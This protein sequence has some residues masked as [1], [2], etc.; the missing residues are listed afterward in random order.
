MRSGN[1]EIR[2]ICGPG[3]AEMQSHTSPPPAHLPHHPADL[4]G[5]SVNRLRGGARRPA[6]PRD[7]HSESQIRTLGPRYLRDPYLPGRWGESGKKKSQPPSTAPQHPLTR[8]ARRGRAA[9]QPPGK[10][11]V[12]EGGARPGQRQPGPTRSHGGSGAAPGVHWQRPRREEERSDQ[13]EEVQ[14][15]GPSLPP[16]RGPPR[17][18][19][20]FFNPSARDPAP[21]ELAGR[22]S[23]GG[24][25]SAALAIAA[26]PPP[27]N[28][29]LTWGAAAAKSEE[30]GPAGA[31]T[32][33]PTDHRGRGRGLE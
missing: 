33:L 10:G 12:G 31:Q 18:G 6:G 11:E 19:G 13:G 25:G 29:P 17:A 15:H 3:H 1:E 24:G 7:M 27:P 4:H 5:R 23:G 30:G 2:R 22:A 26:G 28:T 32:Y 21:S 20:R 9:W 14:D 8:P 16:A